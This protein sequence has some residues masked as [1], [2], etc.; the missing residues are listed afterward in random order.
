MGLL[1][2]GY[3]TDWVCTADTVILYC[4]V[5]QLCT[6]EEVTEYDMFVA[7]TRPPEVHW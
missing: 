7:A 3:L 6:A 2:A 4:C 5:F 1:Q